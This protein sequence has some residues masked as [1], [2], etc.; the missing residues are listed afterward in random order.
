MKNDE[1]PMLK[2]AALGKASAPEPPPTSDL[3]VLPDG[4]I[5]AH[6][7]TPALAG[8]LSQLIPGEK[9]LT[10]RARA[11]ILRASQFRSSRP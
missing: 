7:L 8:L 9:G 2:P 6:N 1:Q 4:R 5:L 10:R 3:L 11:P